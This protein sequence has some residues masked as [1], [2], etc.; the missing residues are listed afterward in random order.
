MIRQSTTLVGQSRAGACDGWCVDSGEAGVRGVFHDSFQGRLPAAL[1][2][3]RPAA[4][5]AAAAAPPPPP[6]VDN[7]SDR[8]IQMLALLQRDGRLIDFLMEDVAGY[9]DAQIGAA[10]RDVHAGCRGVLTR[11]VTL[12]PILPGTEGERMN[13]SPDLVSG[14]GSPARQR[15][16]TSAV[17]GHAAASRLARREDRIAA[18]RRSGQPQRRRASRSRG[19]VACRRRQRGGGPG[20]VTARKSRSEARC[21]SSPLQL[22]RSTKWPKPNPTR[23]WPLRASASASIS[24][25][26]TAR[27]PAPRSKTSRSRIRSRSCRSRSSSSRARSHRSRCCRSFLYVVGDLDFPA[28][29]LRLPWDNTGRHTAAHRRRTGA[30]AR[31]GT[32]GAPASRPPNR[33]CRTRARTARRRSLPWD[34]PERRA[35]DLAGGGFVRASLR[36]LRCRRGT[37]ASRPAMR[38]S[39]WIVNRMFSHRAGVVRRG[40]TRS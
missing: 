25:P 33:G 35:E 15:E 34:A 13:V 2:D 10:V 16:R 32:S 9:G 36:H 11:Y 38:R 29:S 27:S 3:T 5:P 37:R 6:P 31:I 22:I 24:A 28:G 20:V 18:A 19:L 12:E 17:P 8:A 40:G 21:D 26:R 14:G 39:R 23:S 1:Q 4:P 30:Q 7:P